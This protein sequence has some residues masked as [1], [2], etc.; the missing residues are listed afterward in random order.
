M[1]RP[2]EFALVPIRDLHAHE[3]FQDDCVVALMEELRRAG[4][5]NEPIWVSR[6]SLVIL[7]GHHR[8]EAMRRM[9]A[10]RMPAW[11]FE[12]ES[13]VVSLEPWRPGPPIPKAEVIRRGV[14]G[15]LFPPKTTRHKIQVELPPHP[16][17]LADLLAPERGLVYPMGPRSSRRRSPRASRSE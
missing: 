8:V 14:S 17:S 15:H 6:D 10:S 13:E 9:G 4:V 11:L 7:N 5:M 16:T 12:Y 1:T 2:P 3:Q